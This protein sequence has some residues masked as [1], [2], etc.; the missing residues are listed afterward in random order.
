MHEMGGEM[1][2]ISAVGQGTRFVCTIP[3]RRPLTEDFIE[4]NQG[5]K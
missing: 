3:F 4:S 1:D 5:D 2:V